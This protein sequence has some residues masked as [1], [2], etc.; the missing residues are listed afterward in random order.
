M[1]ILYLS[2][3][4]NGEPLNENERIVCIR[5]IYIYICIY[6]YTSY[7]Y[8]YIYIYVYIYNI[9]SFFIQY[10]VPNHLKGKSDV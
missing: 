4:N 5:Y 1:S 3:L 7:I 2:K 10:R 8:I 6:I 9:C